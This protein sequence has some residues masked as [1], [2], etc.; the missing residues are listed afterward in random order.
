MYWYYVSSRYGLDHE[1]PDY[2]KALHHLR[3]KGWQ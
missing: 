2:C 3:T 1:I